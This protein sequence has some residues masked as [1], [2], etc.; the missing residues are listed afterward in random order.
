MT[1]TWTLDERFAAVKDDLLSSVHERRRAALRLFVHHRIA[2]IDPF[3][4]LDELV[5]YAEFL[6]GISHDVRRFT[7]LMAHELLP[8]CTNVALYE[9]VFGTMHVPPAT[10]A[11]LAEAWLGC[12]DAA[13]VFFGN[14]DGVRRV[15]PEAGWSLFHT[16]MEAGVVALSSSRAGLFW[17]AEN[18]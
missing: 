15:P 4:P 8:V 7:R 10:A 14:G 9:I 13:T 5:A 1:A 17:N 18:S 11:A 16:D 3:D 12:F 6:G 2:P